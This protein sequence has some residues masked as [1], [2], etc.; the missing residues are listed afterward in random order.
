L[1][2]TSSWNCR[3]QRL[4]EPF[5]DARSGEQDEPRDLVTLVAGAAAAWWLAAQAQQAGKLPTIG[6]L[7]SARTME[8]AMTAFNQGLAGAGYVVSRNVNLQYRSAENDIGRGRMLVAEFV[9]QQ[10]R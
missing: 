6:W 7:D 5:H 1:A 4:I 8:A 2:G 3:S 9:R 10:W